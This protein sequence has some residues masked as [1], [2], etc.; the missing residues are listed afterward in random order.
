MQESDLGVFAQKETMSTS[1]QGAGPGLREDVWHGL[2][3][4]GWRLR[5]RGM[6]LADAWDRSFKR[7]EQP[8]RRG[9]IREVAGG[10]PRDL[11]ILTRTQNLA[12]KL[13]DG[14]TFS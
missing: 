7:P 13:G 2:G 14:V 3:T 4:C 5:R 10:A 6:G 8:P 11:K 1:H 9:L 12:A